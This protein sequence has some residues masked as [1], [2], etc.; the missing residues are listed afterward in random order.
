MT[1]IK[2]YKQDVLITGF[3][4]TGHSTSSVDDFDGKL[5]CSAV[6]SA[7]YLVANTLG[8]IIKA[9][10]ITDVKDGYMLVKL[11]SKLEESQVTL[12]GFL[13]HS[14]EL[15]K[16]YRNYLKVYSEV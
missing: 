4:I 3:E 5:V 13:L 16:Q 12:N 7:A 10:L 15:A 8:E 1:E 14:N 2:F 6:S 11:S 9:K